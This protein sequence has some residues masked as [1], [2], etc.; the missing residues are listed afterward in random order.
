MAG[1]F[2]IDWS[3]EGTYKNRLKCVFS[4]YGLKQRVNDYTRVT[5]STKTIMDYVIINNTNFTANNNI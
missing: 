2:N 4:D 3:K 1:D 5:A